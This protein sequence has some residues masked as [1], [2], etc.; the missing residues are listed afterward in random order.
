MEKNS[1]IYKSTDSGQTW[2]LISNPRSGFPTGE[3]VGRIGLAFLMV[4]QYMQ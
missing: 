3:G 2:S 4:I 1:G